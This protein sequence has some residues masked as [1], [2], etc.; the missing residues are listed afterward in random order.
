MISQKECPEILN[1]LATDLPI[2]E[3]IIND[4]RSI[5]NDSKHV[6]EGC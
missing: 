4:E 3:I 6:T 5:V 1:E 2:V